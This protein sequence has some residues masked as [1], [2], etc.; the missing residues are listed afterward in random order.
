MFSEVKLI[1]FAFVFFFEKVRWGFGGDL[2]RALGDGFPA[3]TWPFK[4]N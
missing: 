4:M 3:S 1:I 2:Y